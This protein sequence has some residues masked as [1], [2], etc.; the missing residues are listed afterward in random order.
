MMNVVVTDGP[1]GDMAEYA[2]I[3]IAF[4][5][6][7]AFEATSLG[8]GGIGGLALVERPVDPPWAKDYDAVGEHPRDWARRFDVRRWRVFEARE[9]GTLRGG[10]V[11]AWDTPG[12]EMLEGRRDLAVLWDIRVDPAA[13]GMGIGAALFRA[14]AEWARGRGCRWMKVETQDINV[15][16][17]RFYQ[18]MGCELGAIHR[19]AYPGLRG[20]TQ[21]LWYLD[22]AAKTASS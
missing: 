12:V 22:L 2:A 18:R 19:F 17:C 21:L 11:V 10:S 1:M 9:G 14:A 16:A 7:S 6:R 8:L 5:V 20:E 4:E 3:R 15:A 13:R